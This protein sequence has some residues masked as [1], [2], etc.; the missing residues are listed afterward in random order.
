MSIEKIVLG[1]VKTIAVNCDL[2][3]LPESAGYPYV[4][5]SK[6]SSPRGSNLDGLDGTAITLFQVDVYGKS[7]ESAKNLAIQLYGICNI[8]NSSVSHIDIANEFDGYEK[9]TKLFKTVID[10]R[11]SHY[12]S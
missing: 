4:V 11:V 10:F 3:K 7:Y 1:M 9:E 5:V 12:E 8:A 6:V 2:V